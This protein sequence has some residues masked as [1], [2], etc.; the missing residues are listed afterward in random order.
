MERFQHLVKIIMNVA[1]PIIDIGT[2]INF[3]LDMYFN[4]DNFPLVHR[5][6]TCYDS[7]EEDIGFIFILSGEDY[8]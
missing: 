5:I 8:L 4:Y 2:D 7:K 6:R 1:L 3:T